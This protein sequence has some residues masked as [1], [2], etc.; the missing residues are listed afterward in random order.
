MRWDATKGVLEKVYKPEDPD[1][2]SGIL[3]AGNA[4][5]PPTG[6]PICGWAGQLC[7]TPKKSHV[8]VYAILLAI[9][10]LMTG[11]MSFGFWY[12]R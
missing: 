2:W 12:Y 11:G 6:V 10:F 5:K 3:W 8:H 4:T 9:L 1:D 7:E